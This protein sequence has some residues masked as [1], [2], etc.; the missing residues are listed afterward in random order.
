M[1]NADNQ[2]MRQKHGREIVCLLLTLLAHLPILL[3]TIPL[4][5]PDLPNLP[6]FLSNLFNL[7]HLKLVNP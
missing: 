7:S 2:Q 5:Q 4:D 6:E 1:K 3:H